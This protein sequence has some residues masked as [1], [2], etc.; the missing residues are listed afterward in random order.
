M[1]NL[2]LARWRSVN[3]RNGAARFPWGKF[4][5]PKCFLFL[6]TRPI[7]FH[8][9]GKCIH[10]YLLR[11]VIFFSEVEMRKSILETKE[12]E[13]KMTFIRW[14]GKRKGVSEFDMH[15]F[16]YLKLFFTS[17]SRPIM[18]REKDYVY[19]FRYHFR[20]NLSFSDEPFLGDK[21]SIFIYWTKELYEI[22]SSDVKSQ[23]SRLIFHSKK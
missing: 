13:S 15:D 7:I 9:T 11:P 19:L 5:E 18:W 1:A 23:T 12:G 2:I 21:E 14:R 22:N 8:S 6:S 4:H 17:D 3:I 16:K 10:Y 20:Q